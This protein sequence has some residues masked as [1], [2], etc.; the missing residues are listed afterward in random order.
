MDS[1]V[2]A[3][4][5]ARFRAWYDDAVAKEP[6]LPDAVALATVDADGAPSVRMVLLK[7]VEAGS[8]V[9]YTNLES[10]KATEL[11]ANPRAALAFHWKSLKRQVRVTGTTSRVDDADADAYFATRARGAQIGAW[12]SEQSR[13]MEG[14]FALERRV[15]R[16][17][18]KFG[19][20]KVP[21][22]PFWS[23]YL[24]A[25]DEIEFWEERP[26]RLHERV[27]YRRTGLGWKATRLFP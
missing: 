25:P 27:L 15:A 17:T 16:Y 12:A 9:F 7:G 21:R 10:R 24:L 6:D 14:M 11:D 13:E 8:F 22:P 20:G 1:G 23:G 2:Q 19:V 3:D 26:F 4:P 5:V 18:A